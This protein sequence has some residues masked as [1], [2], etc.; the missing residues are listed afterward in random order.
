MDNKYELSNSLEKLS[1]SQKKDFYDFL[2]SLCCHGTEEIQDNQE[3]SSAGYR[4]A[5]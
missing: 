5:D 1:E 4:Q 2:I 3:Q